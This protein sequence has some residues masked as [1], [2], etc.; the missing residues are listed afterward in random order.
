MFE[1]ITQTKTPYIVSMHR[2]GTMKY[3]TLKFGG[4]ERVK[5]KREFD[6]LSSPE[7]RII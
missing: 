5:G 6:A 1:N 7:A 4:L 2:A 3:F